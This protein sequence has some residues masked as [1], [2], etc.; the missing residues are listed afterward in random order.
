MKVKDII[1]RYPNQ[2][3]PDRLKFGFTFEDL[4]FIIKSRLDFINQKMLST[5]IDYLVDRGSLLS[6]VLKY[7]T[8]YLVRA[9]RFGE[10]LHYPEEK[11]AYFVYTGLKRLLDD[12]QQ[13]FVS[14][15]DFEKMFAFLV[16]ILDR[17]GK[18]KSSINEEGINEFKELDLGITFDEFGARVITT[19]F[20]SVP[21]EQGRKMGHYEKRFLFLEALD[22][23]AIRKTNGRISLDP[24][25]HKVFPADS[26]PLTLL[27]QIIKLYVDMWKTIVYDRHI[28]PRKTEIELLLTTCNNS[29]NFLNSYKVGISS[30][31]SHDQSRFSKCLTELKLLL[32]TKDPD[33]YNRRYQ[34]INDL[35]RDNA[36]RIRQSNDK[37][38]VW[39][40]GPKMIDNIEKAL[41]GKE[42]LEPLWQEVKNLVIDPSIGNIK[43]LPV[44]LVH[45]YEYL[46]GFYEVSRAS[47]ILLQ[48]MLKERV[49]GEFEKYKNQYNS[50]IKKAGFSN[51]QEITGS[52]PLNV[53][54]ILQNNY[55]IFNTYFQTLVKDH[56]REIIPLKEFDHDVSLL[57]YDLE[58]YSIE[59]ETRRDYIT[60][61]I[62][63]RMSQYVIALKEEKYYKYV[64]DDENSYILS[65]V[66]NALSVLRRFIEI[67]DKEKMKARISLHYTDSNQRIKYNE[68]RPTITGSTPYIVCSR[69]RERARIIQYERA[70]NGVHQ[71][72]IL[73]TKNFYKEMPEK[74]RSILGLTPQLFEKEENAKGVGDIEYIEIDENKF[75]ESF[76]PWKSIF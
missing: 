50:A 21:S 37:R 40:K 38:Q 41:N 9:F 22:N 58:D 75:I 32:N 73:I 51:L 27:E 39:D 16:Q 56:E 54:N 72:V 53:V 3:L 60:K 13:D 43:F 71:N 2:I 62:A 17:L 20:R 5:A 6:V 44:E 30:W 76:G 68:E 42:I 45:D 11:R 8:G 64:L 34:D 1:T 59:G 26:N 35:L 69:L 4:L 47:T 25:F 55:T 74:V 12:L 31:F 67:L 29:S 15:F 65:N 19:G 49:K 24:D 10:N 23:K 63:E 66:K 28:W 33:E 18:A 48:S 61:S 46:Q 70:Q 52:D 14:Q 57:M 36:T 7:P